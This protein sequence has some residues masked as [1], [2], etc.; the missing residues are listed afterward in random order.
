MFYCITTADSEELSSGDLKLFLQSVQGQELQVVLVL[1]GVS[2][3]EANSCL[4]YPN[5][6]NVLRVPQGGISAVRNVGLHYL[7]TINL[8]GD[9]VVSFPDD[10]CRYPAGLVA[11]ITGE[12]EVTGAELIV[13][14]YGE[15]EVELSQSS[16]LTVEDAAYRSSSVALFIRW[17]LLRRV[18]G[19]NEALGVGSGV[20]S[21]GE[22]NDFALRAYQASSISI[23]KPSLRVWHLEE[24]PT[25][26]RNPKG[27]L[28]PCVLNLRVQGVGR[29]TLR[30]I[31]GSILQDLTSPRKPLVYTRYTVLA[32]HPLK[33]RR[34]VAQRKPAKSMIAGTRQPL[35][36]RH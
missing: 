15:Q 10:D 29:I 21:Y 16:P 2:D 8:S 26:G 14:S 7:K 19:F 36:M 6:R 25:T 3:A 4:E 30:G 33:L 18:G 31:L 24:R 5:V 13:G 22:D 9:D 28:T 11:R 17:S 12:F 34:V 35:K 1:R 32:L 27:Y 20:F 23:S